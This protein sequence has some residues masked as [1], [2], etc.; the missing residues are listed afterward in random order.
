MY[1]V[2]TIMALD[3]PYLFMQYNHQTFQTSAQRYGKIS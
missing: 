1:N 2:H 3:S